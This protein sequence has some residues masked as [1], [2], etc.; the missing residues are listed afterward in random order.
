MSK[1]EGIDQNND[2]EMFY[3]FVRRVYNILLKLGKRVI[4]WNDNIDIS[5]SPDL[6]RD[7]LIHFWR[8]AATDRGPVEGCSM[9]RFLEE[10]FEVLN[11]WY[12]ETYIER[13]FY[14]NNDET[15]KVWSPISV[16]LHDSKYNAQIK[17]GEPCAWGEY[18][19]LEH[20]DWTLPTSIMLFGDRLWNYKP[21]DDA[22]E[23]GIAGTRYQL[24][25]HTPEKFNLFEI[26][27]G[28]MQPRSIDGT[29]MW[30]EKAAKDLS[31][32][33]EILVKLEDS[34]LMTGKLAGEYR[35]SIE[36]LNE[37]RI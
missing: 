10:G 14:D 19:G 7:I 24:G 27:G 3:Y 26:F 28:F 2:T 18:K 21:N 12:P 30:T 35:K 4:M 16:P 6:P 25:I 13:D 23:F 15:I 8:I 32:T 33:Y 9:E 22:E 36:W 11:S 37:K 5:Q 34:Y 31:K 1:R 20:Y 17:G 29:R